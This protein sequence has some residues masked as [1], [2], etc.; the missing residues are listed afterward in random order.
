MS[1]IAVAIHDVEPATFDRCALIRDW[2]ADHGIDR[3]TLLVVPAPDLHPFF[4]RRPDL[5][6]WLLDCRDRGDAIAQQGFRRDS[7]RRTEFEGLDP[8]ATH[9][10]VEAGRRLLELAGIEPRGFVAPGYAYTPALRRELGSTFDW[11]ATV[12]RF[13]RR[14]EGS[15]IVP[16][17][18]LARSPLALRAGAL[19]AGRLL[20]LDLKPADF[21]KT[22]HVLALE[23]VLRNARRTA[24]TYDDLCPSPPF[25]PHSGGVAAAV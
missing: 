9:A 15:E 24:V 22:R 23:A 20:R 4:Q 18:S 13:M 8:L 14:R 21:D 25:A 12:L 16:A 17:L 11:W 2:L 6:D 5:A 1:T 7:G 19:L 3:V 10:S